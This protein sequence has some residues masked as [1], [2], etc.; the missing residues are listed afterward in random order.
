MYACTRRLRY[1]AVGALCFR[2]PCSGSRVD[3]RDDK[4]G[5]AESFGLLETQG[6]VVHDFGPLSLRPLVFMLLCF[7]A[8]DINVSPLR[9]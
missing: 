9:S 7:A 1:G 4:C 8:F 6:F 5:T 2:G 3:L